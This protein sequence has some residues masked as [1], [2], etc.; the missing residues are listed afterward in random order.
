[1]WALPHCRESLQASVSSFT[2]K[3]FLYQGGVSPQASATFFVLHTIFNKNTAL[4]ARCIVVDIQ[5]SRQQSCLKIFL[6]S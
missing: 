5:N 2:L 1:V 6:P 4:A 3:Q